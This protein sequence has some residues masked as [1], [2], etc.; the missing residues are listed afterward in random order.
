MGCQGQTCVRAMSPLAPVSQAGPDSPGDT[1]EERGG[2]K[3]AKH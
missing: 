3:E 2:A 1:Q